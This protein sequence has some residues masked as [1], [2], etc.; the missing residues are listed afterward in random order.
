ML[1]KL[2]S[3]IYNIIMRKRSYMIGDIVR[4]KIPEGFYEGKIITMSKVDKLC[5][6]EVQRGNEVRKFLLTED[7][8]LKKEAEDD[9]FPLIRC[10]GS[11]PVVKMPLTDRCGDFLDAYAND[12]MINLINKL[13]KEF[14]LEVELD[15]MEGRTQALA[16]SVM[17]QDGSLKLKLNKKLFSYAAD[18]Y[19][20]K[21]HREG[22]WVAEDV[23]QVLRHEFGHLETYSILL[24]KK[25]FI[26]DKWIFDTT[27]KRYWELEITEISKLNPFD[28]IAESYAN[29]NYNNITEKIYK[30]MKGVKYGLER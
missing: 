22:F 9:N 11:R 25:D 18:D 10:M 5:F 8:V 2:L 23:E 20:R 1:E 17:N 3:L 12:I 29:P 16:E 15:I 7:V 26:L 13:Y 30:A 6:I 27:G 4:V 28:T 21:R 14:G 19:I 24:K